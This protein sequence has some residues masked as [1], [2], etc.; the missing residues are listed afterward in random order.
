M[1]DINNI[2]MMQYMAS[3]IYEI[4][5]PFNTENHDGTCYFAQILVVNNDGTYEVTSFIE[6][7]EDDLDLT[8]IR[9]I[10][11][12]FLTREAKRVMQK[13]CRLGGYSRPKGSRPSAGYWQINMWEEHDFM[14]Y[15]A[16]RAKKTYSRP[17]PWERG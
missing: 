4:P 8:R 5:Y 12:A 17:Q 7:D 16:C 6:A 10:P 9:F 2:V 11:A 3:G 14:P 1:F 13:R 15:E